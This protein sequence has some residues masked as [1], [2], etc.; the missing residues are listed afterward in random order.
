MT[1]VTINL[2]KTILPCSVI[3]T[4]MARVK[5]AFVLRFFVMK[6]SVYEILIR[7]QLQPILTL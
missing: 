3:L 7:R 6:V 4:A 2:L 1:T 5:E